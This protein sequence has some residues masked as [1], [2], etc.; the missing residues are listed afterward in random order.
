ML[1]HTQA[2]R[3]SS[4]R[5]IFAVDGLHWFSFAKL[6]FSAVPAKSSMYC[7]TSD[8]AAPC[9]GSFTNF[10]QK[11][12]IISIHYTTLCINYAVKF[13]HQWLDYLSP[14]QS[15]SIQLNYLHINYK[16]HITFCSAYQSSKQTLTTEL[17][18]TF[19]V[20]ICYDATDSRKNPR[21]LLFLYKSILADDAITFLSLGF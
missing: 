13:L 10:A 19:N 5:E 16:L 2:S 17:Q 21:C 4:S 20:C 1:A 8:V 14:F 6:W 11:R 18:I 15:V 7:M 12:N 3:L 9:L